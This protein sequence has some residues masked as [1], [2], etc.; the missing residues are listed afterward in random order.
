I[1]LEDPAN[2]NVSAFSI[3]LTI[4]RREV[5]VS[6]PIAMPIQEPQGYETIRMPNDPGGGGRST[7]V[8]D[9]EVVVFDQVVPCDSCFEPPRIPGVIIIDGAIR[10]LKE[11]FSVRLLLM[12]MSGIFTLENVQASLEFP[13][14]G[15]SATLPQDGVAAFDT[16]EPGDG[17]VPGQ[18]EREFIV[19]GDAIGRRPIRVNFGGVVTGPGID[20]PV[21]FNGSAETAVEVKGPPNFLVRVSHPARVDAGVPYELGVEITNTGEAPALYAS[22]ELD[23]GAAAHF[24]ECDLPEGATTPVCTEI[25]GPLVRNLSHL[26][27]GDRVTEKFTVV[28]TD[29]G[30][31]SSCIGL[32]DQNIALQVLVGR[33]GC[34]VGQ[35]PAPLGVV[36]DQPTV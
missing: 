1:D 14:G 2:Y 34:L 9:M 13:D 11:F 36:T 12:N 33:I 7:R 30:D 3:V 29:T 26:F 32:S 10:S 24:A 16:I 18:R 17:V 28:P 35:S 15:L 22:L 6:I 8:Q 4:G 5:P 23:I 31:I 25:P 21:P 19:R 27:P 20:D